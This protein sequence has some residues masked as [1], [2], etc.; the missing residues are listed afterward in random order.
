VRVI[1]AV[2]PETRS[3]PLDASLFF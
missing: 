1:T 2:E 3:T